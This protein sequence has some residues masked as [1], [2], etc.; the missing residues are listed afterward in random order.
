MSLSVRANKK[1][2]LS[3]P[4]HSAPA[5]QRRRRRRRQEVVSARA[6]AQGAQAAEPTYLHHRAAVVRLLTQ[7]QHRRVALLVQHSPPQDPQEVQDPA[8]MVSEESVRRGGSSPRCFA[9][10]QGHSQWIPTSAAS[11]NP[12][13]SFSV[14]GTVTSFIDVSA[15]LVETFV[16]LAQRIPRTISGGINRLNSAIGHVSFTCR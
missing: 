3:S 8:L 16:V 11:R 12:T 13:V 9:S 4:N 1:R 5:E 2:R 6:R 15:G 14:V 10:F 7:V